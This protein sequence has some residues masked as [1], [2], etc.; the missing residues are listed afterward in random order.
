LEF[1]SDGTFTYIAD[2]TYTGTDSFTYRA[3]DGQGENSV[4]TATFNVTLNEPPVALSDAYSVNEDGSLFVP[5]SGVLAN[6]TEPNGQPLSAHLVSGPAHGTLALNAN[7]SFTYTPAANYHG[8]DEFWYRAF[9]GTYYSDPVAVSLNVN[10]VNDAPVASGNTYS[11]DEDV[12]LTVSGSG[13]LGDDSDVDSG[14]LTAAVVTGP[15]HGVLNFNADGSFSYA[16]NAN[17]HGSDS[18]TYRANDGEANSNIA[19]VS[20][21]VNAVNDAP[22]A[23]ND[24]YSL[25]E[26]Q[27]LT[28]APLP[29]VTSLVMVSQPGDYIGQGLTYS[30]TPQ[31]GTFFANRNFD[32]G[33]SVF[34]SGGGESWNLRFAAP[35]EADLTPGHYANAT[36]FPFQEPDEPGLS[37]TGN[38]R[39]SNTLTGHFTVTQ[40][41]Y[42]ANGD[43]LRFAAT[44]EQHSEGLP[45]ALTGEIKI[46][47]GDGLGG[48]LLNDSDVEGNPFTIIVM[49]NPEHGTLSMNVDGS[50]SY[51]PHANYHGA[52]SFTYKLS[53][54]TSEGNVATVSLNVNPVNDF[55]T[56]NNDSYTV[57]ED[58]VLTVGAPGVLA[59]DSD[60]DGDSLTATLVTSPTNGGLVFN[61]DGSFTYTPHANYNGSDSFKYAARDG[62]SFSFIRTVTLNVT[63]VNDAPTASDDS[64]TTAEDSPLTVAAGGLLAN[65]GDVEGTALSA[66]VVSG[67]DH[68]TLVLNSNGSFTYTPDANYHGADSFAYKASDGA[69]ES[70]VATV[71][72]N[73]TAV[74]DAPTAADDAYS[75]AE[76]Q[77][78]AIGASGVLGN[79]SD[80]ESSLTA[81]LVSGPAHGTL[82]LNADGSFTYTPHANYNGSDSFTYKANDGGLD[83]NVATVTLTISAVADAPTAGD[84]TFALDEDNS[85]TVAAD[86]VLGNDGDADGDALSA[87]LV[88]GPSH[89]VLTLN[90]DGSFAYTP[91]A[92][93]HGSDSFTYKAHDGGLD[94]NVATVW[95]TIHAVNDAPTASDDAYSAAE[96]EL[97]AV[98]AGVLAN[99]GDLDGDSL[100]AVLVSGPEHG[101]LT[102]NADGSFTYTAHADYNGSDSFTYK[103]ND[104]SADSNVATVSLM[105][106]AVND[107]PVA[108]AGPDGQSDEGATALFEASGSFDVDGGNL[109]YFWDFGDGDTA[110]GF[111][112]QHA[113]ADEGTYTVTLTV[114]DGLASTTDTLVMTVFKVAPLATVSGPSAGVRGQTQ[115]FTFGAWDP[116]PVDQASDFTYSI[117]WGDGNTET[118]SGPNGSILDHVY[119][120]TGTYTVS[121]QATDKDGVLGDVVQHTITISAVLFQSGNLLV[122]G[123]AASDTINLKV[124]DTS[125]GVRVTINGATQGTFN[126]SGAVFVFAQEGTDNIKLETTKFNGQTRY[127]QD[128][129]FVFGGAGN[130]SLD[131]RGSSADNVIVGD[132]G[133][134]TI[135]GGTGRDILI[136]GLGTDTLRG[137]TGDDLLIGNGTSYDVNLNALAALMAEWG[138]TNASYSVRVGH[139]LGNPGGLN[140]GYFLDP[141]SILSDSA[142]DQLY[143]EGGTDLFFT[144]YSSPADAANDRSGSETKVG[145]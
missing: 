65:D 98:A 143:G 33:V 21:A 131:A 109:T 87:I 43:V 126:P 114:S 9:D 51:T 139:L 42:A 14:T 102:L 72:L 24:A 95:L 129:A 4:A 74:D 135:W 63:S 12:V 90:S 86:G 99:D 39:G 145:L 50:F 124:A 6:D 84:D 41:V 137:G 133:N 27:T 115:T 106:S 66:V 75:V 22:V 57:A 103:A 91:H 96:D 38:G 123:T 79:D 60:V 20:I 70:N 94:S 122:G 81:A 88:N 46:N 140:D 37:V 130:D 83:S 120:S 138:R 132:A 105:I 108:A 89:G 53:D 141:N 16:P 8:S 59:N 80:V 104:G 15:S 127:I 125:G 77:T 69:A 101:T 26:D 29:G 55:P 119:A 107:A 76:D 136:G 121:V 92:N 116:S 97:L 52:D 58:Q 11:V 3:F 13:V 45:P 61:A 78:L 44:F 28:V 85:L 73:V 56:A 112:V 110:N 68:G 25:N 48:I 82:A 31:T 49:S 111:S 34:Y 30:F 18:F 93:F 134:D 64:Y 10:P 142:I 67:P 128:A 62:Q 7:G 32:N 19:T 113:Y 118:V 54:G 5:S 144:G 100:S 36:R 23:V 2:P 1:N 71:S 117:N 17:Y 35:F 47:A 40:A